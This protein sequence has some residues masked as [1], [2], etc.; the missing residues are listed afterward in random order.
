MMPTLFTLV[1]DHLLLLVAILEEAEDTDFSDLGRL[2]LG[3]FASAIVI[4][5]AF[6]FVKVRL[7]E[8]SPARHGFISI[9]TTQVSGKIKRGDK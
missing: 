9:G 8:K 2:L 3:G 1:H 7:R 6:V 4:A 5:L